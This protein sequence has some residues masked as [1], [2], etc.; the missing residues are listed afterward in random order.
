MMNSDNNINELPENWW[1]NE[2]S[3]R[4]MSHHFSRHIIALHIDYSI[5]G[6][7]Y[8]TTYTGCLLNYCQRYWWITAGPS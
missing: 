6:N 1:E 2:N 5:N 3:A 7:I 8:G 4:I